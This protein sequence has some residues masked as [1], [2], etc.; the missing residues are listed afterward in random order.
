M[1]LHQLRYFVEVAKGGNF[2]RAAERCFVTQPTLSHQIKKLEDELGE[3]LLQRRK[4]GVAPTPFGQQFL[5][6]ALVVLAELGAA[7]EE[8]AAFRREVKGR[9]RVGAIPTVAPYVLPGLLR[10]SRRRYPD[11]SFLVSEEPTEVLLQQ[12]RRGALDIAVVSP[13]INGAE[14]EVASLA[15]DELLATLPRGHELAAT[16]GAVSLAALVAEPLVLM[17]EAHCLRGQAL[18]LC[19]EAR[20]EVDVAIESSQL[21][22]VL[23]LV[24]AGLGLSLTPRMALPHVAGRR[25]EFRSIGPTPVFRSIG[26][27]WPRQASRTRAFGVFAEL[28]KELFAAGWTR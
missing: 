13:P 21:D 10:E 23:G 25:V 12:L 2:T 1:E 8:A 17:K 7:Q 22:T 19:R 16:A 14:W 27:V 5:A 18:Q 6:R 24:E 20:L 28:A 3:P 15:E 11:L 9:L 4:K 26:L